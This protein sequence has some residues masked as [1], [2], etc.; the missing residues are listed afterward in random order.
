MKLGQR[1]NI[2]FLYQHLEINTKFLL[3]EDKKIDYVEFL[4]DESLL[5]KYSFPFWRF[6]YTYWIISRDNFLPSVEASLQLR[7]ALNSFETI[8]G[9]K[10]VGNQNLGPVPVIKLYS[11]YIFNN[12][13]YIEADVDGRYATSN[14]F[15]GADYDFTGSILD[16][17]LNL[18]FILSDSLD[19]DINL[20]YLGE[21]AEST[22]QDTETSLS[23][24]YTSNNLST[25][26]LSIGFNFHWFKKESFIDLAYI[27]FLW[28]W[29]Y[30]HN[31]S[32]NTPVI[33]NFYSK[34]V[35][36]THLT[37]PT[38]LRV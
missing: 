37:L 9:S 4:K 26:I 19:T 33:I 38:I 31:N 18:E 15:N 7:N 10:F 34:S 21:I 23:D 16:A 3:E 30:T 27:R 11:K 1:H 22:S 17:N 29:F 25:F 32:Q 24:R 13:L 35:S 28:K 8:D 36:Y 20:R 14:W 2:T 6:S 5:A 12:G